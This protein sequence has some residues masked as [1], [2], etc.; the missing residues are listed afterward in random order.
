LHHKNE[1]KRIYQNVKINLEEL[2][3]PRPAENNT[4]Q[5]EKGIAWIQAPKVWPHTKGKGILI[6]NSDTGVT[7]THEAIRSNYAGVEGN[8]HNFHWWD[9]STPRSNVPVDAHGHG[10]HCMGTKVGHTA[11]EQIGVAPEAKWIN[12]RSLGPGASARTVL[13]CLQF[14]LAPTDLQGNN[15]DPNKRPHVTSHSYLCNGCALDNAVTALLNAGVEVVV[16]AGNSGSR[17]Q[18]ITEPAAYAD[19]LAVAALNPNSDQAAFFSSRGPARNNVKPQVSAPGV[20]VRSCGRLSGYVQMSGT[21]MACPHVAGAIGLLWSGKPALVRQ[22]QKTREI[23]YQSA[24]KNKKMHNVVLLKHQ[25]MF[26]VGVQ[27]I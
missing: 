20:N 16:A 14:F 6:A 8:N 22:I 3:K 11:L 26:M 17:C 23:F 7:H 24:K 25:I 9:G 19:T 5:I 4:K 1:V 27:L 15:A 12:C 21:S 18:S 10:T 13:A 2:E